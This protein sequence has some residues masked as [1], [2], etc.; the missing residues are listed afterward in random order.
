MSAPFITLTFG[1]IR[2]GRREDFERSNATIAQLVEDEEPRVIA[3]HASLT[4]DGERFAGLQFHPDADSMVHHLQVV[5]D[6]VE[7]IS[8]TLEIEE[9][10]VLG[11]SNE[12]IDGIMKAMSAGGVKV[13]HL[14]NHVAG[15]TRSNAAE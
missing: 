9:F 10:K 1:R 12:A 11:P 15:F 3:F 4:E 6:A 2:E 8:G 13:E 5:K 14:P 7:D